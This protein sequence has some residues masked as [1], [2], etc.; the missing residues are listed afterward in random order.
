MLIQELQ[1]HAVDLVALKTFYCDI[2]GFKIKGDNSDNFT[3]ECG[4]SKLTFLKTHLVNTNPYYHFAFN[5]PSNQIKE[6]HNWL[7]SRNV[8]VMETGKDEE[9][10]QPTYIVDFDEWRAEAVYFYDPAGNIVEFIARQE[11][12]RPSTKP[13]S[14]ENVI[15]IS[16]IG[17]VAVEKDSKA[18]AAELREKYDI[19]SFQKGTNRADF[20]ALGADN[21]LILAF[22]EGRNYFPTNLPAARFPLKVLFENRKNIDCE[23]EVW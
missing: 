3:V 13:F 18:Y 10:D 9:T 22:R 14:I 17:L 19:T 8:D 16:E 5:I 1:L 15:S 11:F 4:T 20:W 6:A 2:L 12:S 23:L 7:K 21:G